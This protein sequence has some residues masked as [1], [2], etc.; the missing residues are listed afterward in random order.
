MAERSTHTWLGLALA[1]LALTALPGCG[2]PS[3]SMTMGITVADALQMRGWVP[4]GLKQTIELDRVKGGEE[5][6][7][8][9]GSRVSG[10]ALEQALDDSLRGVGML[11][12][13]SGAKYQLRVQLLG[14]VQPILGADFTATMTIHYLLVD[15]QDGRVLYQRSVRSA[16]TADFGESLLSQPDRARL[17]NEGAVRTNIATMLR[18][19]MELRTF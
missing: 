19:L 16:H 4:E 12:P 2:T 6:S 14:L 1:G 18:D 5:T 17:A 10:L 3:Q 7:M 8:W 9:W 15:K 11:A 13:V